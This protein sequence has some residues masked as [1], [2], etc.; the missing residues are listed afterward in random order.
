MAVEICERKGT[1]CK[2]TI[3][4]AAKGIFTRYHR[5]YNIGFINSDGLEDE[6]Q[7]DDV[8]SIKE[9]AELFSCFCREN[10]FRKDTVTYVERA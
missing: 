8:K 4:K 5:T 3:R 7:F 10:G 1:W 6:T 9:L 2:M